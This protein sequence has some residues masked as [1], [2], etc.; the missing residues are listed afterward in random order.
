MKIEL[1]FLSHHASR[2][3]LVTTTSFRMLLTMAVPAII[4]Q[5]LCNK[6]FFGTDDGKKRCD[7]SVNTDDQRKRRLKDGQVLRK[8]PGE[9]A[10]ASGPSGERS[11]LPCLP[12][13]KI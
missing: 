3:T 4:L 8:V 6:S 12:K 13:T 11:S 7:I 1:S 9:A 2:I 5:A 10:R